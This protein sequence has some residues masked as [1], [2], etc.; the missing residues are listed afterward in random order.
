MVSSCT[1]GNLV[2]YRCLLGAYPL[3]SSQVSELKLAVQGTSRVPQLM[4]LC[5]IGARPT[6]CPWTVQLFLDAG[7]EPQFTNEQLASRDLAI[8]GI[9][10]AL[11]SG[12]AHCLGGGRGPGGGLV[13]LRGWLIRVS[14][15]LLTTLGKS[16]R[17]LAGLAMLACSGTSD[18]IWIWDTRASETGWSSVHS[19][20]RYSVVVT[21]SS[22][23]CDL[24]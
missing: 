9:T 19:Y 23:R 4:S 20:L 6:F 14:C 8:W 2:S 18:Q 15:G 21:G 10:D 1:L 13:S 16:S 7:A 5:F 24:L 17:S 3:E 11:G 12:S 22:V